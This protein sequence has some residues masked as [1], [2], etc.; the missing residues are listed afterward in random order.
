MNIFKKVKLRLLFCFGIILFAS[1]VVPTTAKAHSR[2]TNGRQAYDI[3]RA[4]GTI[5]DALNGYWNKKNG[6]VGWFCHDKKVS[7]SSSAKWYTKGYY[8]TFKK[9]SSASPAFTMEVGNSKYPFYPGVYILKEKAVYDTSWDC[10]QS[11]YVDVPWVFDE[12]Q[13]SDKIKDYVDRYRGTKQEVKLDTDA[14]GITTVYAQAVIGVK[15]KRY[16]KWVDTGAELTSLVDWKT[17]RAWANTSTFKNHY[18]I[19]IRIKAPASIQTKYVTLE[20]GKNSNGLSYDAGVPLYYDKNK[21]Y[22][23]IYAD[24]LSSGVQ[25]NITKYGFVKKRSRTKLTTKV[26]GSDRRLFVLTGIKIQ[27]S[28]DKKPLVWIQLAPKEVTENVVRRKYLFMLFL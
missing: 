8:I 28:E 7:P 6:Y 10:T 2:Q 9:I 26:N 13:I 21:T 22:G 17:K 19:P 16:G 1:L 15:D 24:D 11:G 18:N 4:T 12:W 25:Y 3:G 23:K 5:Y 20:S 14:N 27:N